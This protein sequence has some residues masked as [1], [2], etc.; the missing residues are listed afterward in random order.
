MHGRK[1]KSLFCSNMAKRSLKVASLCNNSLDIFPSKSHAEKTERLCDALVLAY[2]S[3]FVMQNCLLSMWLASMWKSSN[4]LLNLQ[5]GKWGIS[6]VQETI[7]FC[8]WT[9]NISGRIINT[10]YN[11]LF[12]GWRIGRNES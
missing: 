5:S 6:F 3:S 12:E 11:L 9:D 4:L 7:V 2:S 1:K 8:L 10:E